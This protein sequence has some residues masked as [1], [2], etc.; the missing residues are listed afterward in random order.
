IVGDDGAVRGRRPRVEAVRGIVRGANEAV[1]AGINRAR[2]HAVVRIVRVHGRLG[3]ALTAVGHVR[4]QLEVGR[5]LAIDAER[6]LV[7]V[8]T[9]EVRVD[10]RE[11]L[12][13][14]QHGTD[15]RRTGLLADLEPVIAVGI[16]P[17][18]LF[19]VAAVLVHG[20]DAA[21]ARRQDVVIAAG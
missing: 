7:G 18:V 15:N 13:V 12:A 9:A 1:W 20:A 4:A 21:A 10:R 19:A 11:D 17:G 8:R 16:V 2:Q 3:G 6:A 5:Q 14:D